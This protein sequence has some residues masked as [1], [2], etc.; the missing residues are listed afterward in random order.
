MV[1]CSAL[2]SALAGRTRGSVRRRRLFAGCRRRRRLR[3]RCRLSRR[4]T[5][6]SELILGRLG[7]SQDRLGLDPVSRPELLT[8]TMQ[9]ETNQIVLTDAAFVCRDAQPLR[10]VLSDSHR[11]RH[12][13]CALGHR[14][15]KSTR[16]L[17]HAPGKRQPDSTTPASRPP[18]PTAAPPTKTAPTRSTCSTPTN[19]T[20]PTN[21]IKLLPLS[22]LPWPNPRWRLAP[23]GISGQSA[24]ATTAETIWDTVGPRRQPGFG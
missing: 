9:A 13:G 14:A 17:P 1:S 18:A 6:G 24:V 11:S 10:F 2:A 16:S 3:G 5:R 8:Q 12:E 15:H 22:C 7:R 20:S 23:S 21:Q 19:K 4:C